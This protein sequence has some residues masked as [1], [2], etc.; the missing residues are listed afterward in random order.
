MKKV[1]LVTGGGSG[2]GEATSTAFAH[3]GVHVAVADM[4]LANAERVAT[5]IVRAGGSAKSYKI[6][7]SD[8]A[9]VDSINGEI[10]SAF[11][12]LHG[13]VN[14]SGIIG[15]LTPTWEQ[16]SPGWRK[17]VSVNLDGVF[18]CMRHEI[19]AMRKSGGCFFSHWQLLPSRWWFSS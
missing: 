1:A 18:Y 12:G 5:E 10:V 16:T 8:D 11:G 19:S 6:D 3:K 4:D 15:D 9:A 7:V 2:N 17:V 14:N 13:G